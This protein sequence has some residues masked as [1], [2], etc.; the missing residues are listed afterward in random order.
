[1]QRFLHRLRASVSFM[2]KPFLV[3]AAIGTFIGIL[4]PTGR[5]AAPASTV[6][7][8]GASAGTVSPTEP[9]R[10]ITLNRRADGHFYIDG[11]VNGTEAHF[12]IDTGASHVALT[13][14]D[15][16]RLG[17]D[18]SPDEMDYVAEGA[19]G[20]VRGA[21]VT[22]DRVSIGGRVV[23]NA[24]AMVLDG[25]SVSLLG[26]SVLTQLGTLEMNDRQMIIR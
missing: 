6:E 15:A 12:L 21:V 1:M 22:L 7:N 4:M 5:Q 10:E 20:P 3:L 23:T 9:L 13:M 19:G 2:W 14:D 16:K 24:R 11:L 25:L 26:Q 18:V 8:D 17:I